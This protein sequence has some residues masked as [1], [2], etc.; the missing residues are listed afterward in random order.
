MVGRGYYLDH[1]RGAMFVVSNAGMT[2]KLRGSREWILR[3]DRNVLSLTDATIQAVPADPEPIAAT[4][5]DRALYA[6]IRDRTELLGA[7]VRIQ[8][9]RRH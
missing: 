2:S 8:H 3:L 7:A 6:L 9:R 1:V 4:D 5:A